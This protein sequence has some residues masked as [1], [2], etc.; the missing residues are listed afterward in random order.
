MK[1]YGI[2]GISKLKTAIE[3]KTGNSSEIN[4]SLINVLKSVDLN[5]ELVLL[6]TR[7]NGFAT[8]LYPVISEFNYV[9]AKLNNNDKIYLLD[10]TSKLKP[11]GQLPYQCLNGYGRVMD[12]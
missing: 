4:I 11:F 6:S 3:N 9:I 12:F 7:N 8:K 5:A 10:A 2:F 1:K